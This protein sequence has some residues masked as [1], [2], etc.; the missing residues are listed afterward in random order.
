VIVGASLPAGYFQLRRAESDGRIYQ[1]IGVRRFRS[2]VTHGDPMV[3]L[4]RWIDPESHTHLRSSMLSEREEKA[5]RAEKIH[6]G[7]LLGSVPSALWALLVRESWFAIYLLVANVPMNIYPILL[8]RY[9][10]A[11][12][13]S[14]SAR[15]DLRTDS[16]FFGQ[17]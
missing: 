3:R 8:Q 2:I 5:K 12:L 11:R 16:R 9:T 4:M 14:I 17:V 7:M 13:A 15:M 6:W 10:R 1:A